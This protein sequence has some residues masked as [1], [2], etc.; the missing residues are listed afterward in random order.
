[1]RSKFGLAYRQE[2]EATG[3]I[4]RNVKLDV[5]MD[6]NEEAS[7]DYFKQ[8]LVSLCDCMDEYFKNDCIRRDSY[9]DE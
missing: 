3:V 7:L 4:E 9:D 5:Y 2:N 6:C 1:M 8:G